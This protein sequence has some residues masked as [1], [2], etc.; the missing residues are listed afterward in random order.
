M[1][2]HRLIPVLLLKNGLLVRSELFN[3]HQIIGNP[4]YEVQR[5]N[6]WNVDELIYLDITREGE[7]DIRRDDHKTKEMGGPL[8]ILESVSKTCFMP[9]TWGG[10]IRT[11]DDM[12]IRFARGA[13]K[14]T[15]NT[16]A[17]ENPGLVT[18]GAR[19]FGNQAMVVSMDV[20][21]TG[22]SYEVF[23][24]GGSKATGLEPVAWAR[25]AERLGAGEI[26]LQSIDRDG[27]GEGY[28]LELIGIVSH[29]IQIPLIACSGVGRFEDYAAG[30]KAGASAAAAANIWHFK[31]L[32][33]RQGKRAMAR[34]GVAV[35]S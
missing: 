4:L 18:E 15:L 24:H 26:L 25:E 19:A 5:F 11:L 3:L 12:R 28:D 35:R 21:K 16:A 9:L 10:R 2:R 23:T 13:D 33:D 32:T 30:I 31:E 17:V 29:A 20:K 27:T 14:I 34:A 22:N 7:Y 6:D 8:D 1:L